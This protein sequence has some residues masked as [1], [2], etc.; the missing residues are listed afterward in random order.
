METSFAI[1]REANNADVKICKGSLVQLPQNWAMQN[2]ADGFLISPWAKA[3]EI[4]QIRGQIQSF[5]MDG[6]DNFLEGQNLNLS[7]STQI[8]TSFET[9]SSEVLSIQNE[10]SLGNI[11]KAVASRVLTDLV[12]FEVSIISNWY[13]NLIKEHPLALVALVY[14]P[15]FGLWIGASPETLIQLSGNV[16]TTMSLAGTLVNGSDQWTNKEKLEQSVTSKFIKEILKD[17]GLDTPFETEIRETKSGSLRHLQTIFKGEID[18]NKVSEFLMAISPTPAV[19]GYPKEKAVSW[20]QEHEDFE[21][22]LFAGFWGPKYNSVLNLN[23]NLRC[24]KIT[25]NKQLFYAGCGVN[26]GS[27]VQKEWDET[28]AKMNVT[29][30]FRP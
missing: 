10:I 6:L 9:F 25:K 7:E 21:R 24:A 28:G 11:E 20:I 17:L 30:N 13:K 12:E 29:A 26:E 23:V 4:F 22:E 19:G 2:I 15:E 27:D 3:N 16:L 1:F 5:D 8:S 14:T 18:P